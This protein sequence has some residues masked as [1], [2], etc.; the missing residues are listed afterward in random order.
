MT[1]RATYRLQF[2]NGMDFAKA[3]GIVPYL[4][5]LGIS[6]LYASPLFA[7]VA[8]STHGYDVIDCNA[9]E[10]AIG[11]MDGLFALSDRLRRAGMGLILDIVPNHMAASMQNNW[12]RDIV[13]WGAESAYAGHF[14]VDWSRKLTLP[15]LSASFE[16]VLA[17]NEISLRFDEAHGALALA[18]FDTLLPLHPPSY[19]EALAPIADRLPSGMTASAAQA[20]SRGTSWREGF[21]RLAGFEQELLLLSRDRAHLERIHRLQPWRLMDWRDAGHALSYR[22]FFE[23]AGLAGLRV[24]EERVFDDVHRLTLS[25]IRDGI[26]DGLRIDHVDGLAEPAAYLRR[27]REAVGPEHYLVVE[28]ILAEDEHLPAE[29]PVHGTTGYE[30]IRDISQ[31]LVDARG[32]NDLEEAY[33]GDGKPAIDLVSERRRAKRLIVQKNF[34]GELGR[35]VKLGLAAGMPLTERD[36]E[37]AL[38]EVISAFPVYRTYGDRRGMNDRDR[39]RLAD[40]AD[41]TRVAGSE[42][43]GDV[44]HW[45]V[46]ML[47]EGRGDVAWELRRRFQQ[48][49]SAVMAKAVEDTLFYRWHPF[50][51]L[52]EVGSDPAQE[53]GGAGRFHR[54]M[55]A[56]RRLHPAGQLATST[57]DTKRGEDARARLYALSERSGDWHAAMAR[58]RDLN[59]E[60]SAGGP[61]GAASDAGTEWLV[62]QSLAAIWPSAGTWEDAARH[63]DLARRLVAFLEKAMREAKLHTSWTEVNADYERSVTGF[64]ERI[65]APDNQRFLKDFE[66]TLAPFIRAGRLNSLAQTLVKLTAPGIPDIYQ[67]TETGDFSLV[68]PDNRRPVDFAALAGGLT[69][70]PAWPGRVVLRDGRVKQALIA[71]VLALRRDSPDIFVHGSYEPLETRGAR[72]SHIVSYL[73]RD[74][75]DAVLVTVPSL[76]FAAWWPSSVQDFW[77]DTHIVLPPGAPASFGDVLSDA[78]LTPGREVMASDLFRDWPVALSSTVGTTR[79]RA[80]PDWNSPRR[81]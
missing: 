70:P 16:D 59:R 72:A 79:A 54:A 71:A 44:L 56:G 22:R 4:Q 80:A 51:A 27:L 38:V 17:G 34:A 1:P 7:A 29:W 55:A 75:A 64:A 43:D 42:V 32:R 63:S 73:R 33:S 14:D 26:V 81:V 41:E 46:E 11:G 57:H 21:R 2:R 18:Y 50:V 37:L 3:A 15:V 8:G 48:L 62:Y 19:G 78:P 20:R 77:Q 10:P 58:W 49:C 76:T 35:L 6:H 36:L 53:I 67:G 28:K 12:W 69:G 25:L 68:D 47:A 24:E 39:R 5:R 74:A 13:E 61:S 45:L 52:N 31:I 9:V 65:L 30:F 60:R 23:I 66:A 40:V